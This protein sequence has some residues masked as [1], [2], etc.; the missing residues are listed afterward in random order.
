MDVTVI[1][2]ALEAHGGIHETD[3]LDRV[4]DVRTKRNPYIVDMMYSL[5][6]VGNVI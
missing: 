3:L 1:G 5:V 4:N 6:L 2:V